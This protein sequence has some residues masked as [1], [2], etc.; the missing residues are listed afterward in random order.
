MSFFLVQLTEPPVNTRA[1]ALL[2]SVAGESLSRHLGKILP[3]LLL[4][5]G[6]KAHG[7][8]EAQVWKISSVDESFRVCR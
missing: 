8:E 1:L 5:L 4:A 7:P 6:N 3:A 2:S